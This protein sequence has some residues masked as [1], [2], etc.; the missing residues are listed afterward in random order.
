MRHM[1]LNSDSYLKLY[2]LTVLGKLNCFSGMLSIDAFFAVDGRS[3]V[4]GFLFATLDCFLLS[5]VISEALV[6]FKSSFVI[7]D[8]INPTTDT[9]NKRIFT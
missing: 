9:D 3:I 2:S 1:F 4:E 7:M 5:R 6:R 8:S